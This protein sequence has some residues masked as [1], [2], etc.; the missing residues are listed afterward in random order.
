M[1]GDNILFF[2][3]R[4]I[5]DFDVAFAKAQNANPHLTADEVIH[6]LCTDLHFADTYSF[7]IDSWRKF[8]PQSL[9]DELYPTDLDSIT[10]YPSSAGSR[11][12]RNPE[13]VNACALAKYAMVNGIVDRSAPLQYIYMNSRPSDGDARFVERWYPKIN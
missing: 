7:S 13:N 1:L 11:A 9:A 2:N 10:I 3:C 8:D 6:M 4:N 12:E 5:I